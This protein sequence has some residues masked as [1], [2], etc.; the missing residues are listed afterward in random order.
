MAKD[1]I[2][3]LDALRGLAIL[4]IFLCNIPLVFA[5]EAP[6]SMASWTVRLWPLSS[7]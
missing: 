1:R 3:L 2:V 4:G 5:P 6:C 7:S